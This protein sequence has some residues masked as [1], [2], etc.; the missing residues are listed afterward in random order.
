MKPG[1][2]ELMAYADGEL[3]A[4]AAARVEAAIAADP[5]LADAVARHRALRQDLRAAFAGELDAPVPERLSA[6]LRAPAAEVVAL[7][8]ARARR[9]PRPPARLPG[10]AAVAA[11]LA[12]G[13]AIGRFA[14]SPSPEFG[15]GEGGALV[16]GGALADALETGLASA[17]EDGAVQLG[18]T[19]RDAGG[20]WCRSFGLA[21]TAAVAGLAC[22]DAGGRWQVPAV[23]ETAA[24][25]GELRQAAVALP[26]A[27]LA[28]IE[29]R[30]AGEP[31]DADAERAARDAGWR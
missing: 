12:L 16:A 25:A 22:R 5:A 20:R 11:A 30:I 28:E 24:P 19:F 29:H 14:P 4:A 1:D 18:L 23:A 2:E 6:L 26:P 8:A 15:I 17:P 10:W 9:V 3:D 13:L 31:L 21:R 27:V 7:D